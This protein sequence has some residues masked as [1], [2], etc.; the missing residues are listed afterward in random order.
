MVNNDGK[1]RVGF[2]AP[3]SLGQASVI[4]ESIEAAGIDARTIG[5]VEAHGTGTY[6]GDPIE[7]AGLTSAFR[8]YT[9]DNGF[10]ALGSTKGNVGH[11]NNAAGVAGFIKAVHVVREGYI[12]PT[13]NVDRPSPRIDFPSSPF[14]LVTE[15]MPW[16]KKDGV[17]RRAGVSS[18][19]IGGTNAH[20]ILE[21]PPEHEPEA[22]DCP[23]VFILSAAS[24]DGAN[25]LVDSTRTHLQS[26]RDKDLRDIAFTLQ[27]GRGRYPWRRAVVAKTASLAAQALESPL[28]GK[29]EALIPRIVWM[30]PGLEALSLPMLCDLAVNEPVVVTALN[31]CA[32]ILRSSFA[33]DLWQ[34]FRKSSSTPPEPEAAFAL[35]SV[36]YALAA[37]W[38]SWG[39]K[40]DA[41]MGHDLG[42]IAA[43]CVAEVI[44]L[45][46]GFLLLEERSRL[47][48]RKDNMT[49]LA[50]MCSADR[51]AAYLNDEAEF[52]SEQGRERLLVAVSGSTAEA[53]GRTL[54]GAHIGWT[55]LSSGLLHLQRPGTLAPDCLER[56]GRV[57]LHSPRIPL[58][59]SVTA[60]WLNVGQAVDPMHWAKQMCSPAR[61]YSGANAALTSGPAIFVE[62]GPGRAL[63]SLV[64]ALGW[65]AVP[66]LPDPENE[67]ESV[68]VRLALSQLWLAGIEPDWKSVR[69][70]EEGW[71]CSLPTYPFVRAR[72][73][74]EP[75]LTDAIG[76]VTPN[77]SP[78]SAAGMNDDSSRSADP[79]TATVSRI[80]SEL[81]GTPEV[82]LEVSFFTLGGDSLI[83]TQLLA[84]LRDEFSVELPLAKVFASPTV[85]GLVTLI[86]SELT[87]KV[88]GM[89]EEEVD[90]VLAA[91]HN[92]A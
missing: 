14:R 7:V 66:S 18:F 12:P 1:A 39:I 59:S 34:W 13:I 8:E 43:A 67:N 27:S 26:A 65:D 11:L 81:L 61:F 69:R 88:E 28:Q 15:G 23:Q 32:E 89:S 52:V 38:R 63:S 92:P 21:Q 40:P 10:C 51:I 4:R 50:V 75:K 44:S 24:E 19:G 91:D 9:A 16:P 87:A 57:S 25:R 54:D 90:A 70:G 5:Y 36:E 83:A 29:C 80:F 58:I 73:W 53:L 37:L 45:N 22:T 6:L 84:R 86:E 82:D 85:Q 62:M 17:P 79:V 41:V 49:L 56:I 78:S 3:S 48:V 31:Q 46:D 55:R 72:H 30:F 47:S 77:S 76:A 33:L 60:E 20:A 74:I 64:Q 71:R 2:T 35:L 68:Q 42:E